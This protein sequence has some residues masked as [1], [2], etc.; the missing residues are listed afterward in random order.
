MIRNKKNRMRTV[1]VRVK[2]KD[3][4]NHCGIP[5]TNNLQSTTGRFRPELQPTKENDTFCGGLGSCSSDLPFSL[6]RQFTFINVSSPLVSVSILYIS[7]RILFALP[8][9]HIQPFFIIISIHLLG[10]IL[11]MF[12]IVEHKSLSPVLR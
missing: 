1:P 6:V 12:C 2:R 8:Q 3:D 4:T 5:I 10:F 11:L 7:I 9:K